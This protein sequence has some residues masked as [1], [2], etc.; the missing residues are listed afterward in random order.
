MAF[1]FDIGLAHIQISKIRGYVY[2]I[3][4]RFIFSRPIRWHYDYFTV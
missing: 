2:S 1:E 4:S 3:D